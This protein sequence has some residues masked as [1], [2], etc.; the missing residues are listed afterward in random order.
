LVCEEAA[1]GNERTCATCKH[2]QPGK[3]S[4]EMRKLLLARC[5]LGPAWTFL[6]PLSTCERHVPAGEKAIAARAAWLGERADAA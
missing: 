3:T 5:R 6:P 2:W 4:E 1:M